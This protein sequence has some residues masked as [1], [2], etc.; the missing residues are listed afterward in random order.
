MKLTAVMSIGQLVQEQAVATGAL[1]YQVQL[2][3][4]VAFLDAVLVVLERVV[5]GRARLAISKFFSASFAL[6]HVRIVATRSD[7]ARDTCRRQFMKQLLQARLL[8]FAHPLRCGHLLPFLVL[9]FTSHAEFL[10]DLLVLVRQETFVVAQR[11]L[12]DENVR[13]PFAL[14]YQA[15]A[16]VRVALLDAVHLKLNRQLHSDHT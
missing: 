9:R 15:Q 2:L 16:A 3:V 11:L 14:R 10:L 5:V 8:T 1:L 6:R 7:V 12:V 4:L 13:T